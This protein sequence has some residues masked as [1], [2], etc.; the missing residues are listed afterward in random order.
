MTIH[1]TTEEA[2]SC[3]NEHEQDPAPHNTR[4]QQAPR[5]KA[6]LTLLA[7]ATSGAARAATAWLIDWINDHT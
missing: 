1:R 4:Q 7:A 6:A 2:S 3:P 5:V